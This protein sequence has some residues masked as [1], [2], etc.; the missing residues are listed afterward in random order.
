[1]G[2]T[3]E[4]LI[5]KR[6]DY[7]IYLT[8]IQEWLKV[9][10]PQE[11]SSDI[12]SMHEEIGDQGIWVTWRTHSFLYLF[13]GAEKGCRLLTGFLRYPGANKTGTG[14]HPEKLMRNF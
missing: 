9:I 8:Y 11:I 7:E 2:Q 1:M 3:L 6:E 4:P 10:E 5:K 12:K 14:N 13:L